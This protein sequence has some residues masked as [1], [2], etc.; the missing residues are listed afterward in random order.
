MANS[1]VVTREDLANVI[2]ALGANLESRISYVYPV[3]GT[4]AAGE[5]NKWVYTGLNFTVPKGHIYIVTL[6]QAYTSG[7]PK[8]IGL[9]AADSLVPTASTWE[10]RTAPDFAS[11][12]EE[13]VEKLTCLLDCTNTEQTYYIFTYRKNSITT[14][15]VNKYYVYG[16]DINISG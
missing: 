6:S 8:G 14:G 2:G 15:Y 12:V 11:Y 10:T 1:E 9:N 16:L 13:G 3:Y 5:A 4:S 7:A